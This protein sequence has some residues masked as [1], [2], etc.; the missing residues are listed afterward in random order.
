[1]PVALWDS[2]DQVI[3]IKS[4]DNTGKPS[5]TIIDYKERTQDDAKTE[6]PKIEYATKEQVDSM[7][8]QF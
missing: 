7:K 1:V 3:Y 5:M 6:T 2:E 8:D 4:I